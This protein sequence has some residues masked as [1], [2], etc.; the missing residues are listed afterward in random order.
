MGWA[1]PTE[2]GWSALGFLALSGEEGLELFDRAWGADFAQLVRRTLGLGWRCARRRGLGGC[3]RASRSGASACAAWRWGGSLAR[4]LAGVAE[5]EREG[6]VLELVRGEVA[7]VLGHASAAGGR[8]AACVQG[9]GFDSLAAVELRNR[10]G[11]VTGLRLPATLVFDYPSAGGGGGIPAGRG[12]WRSAPACRCGVGREGDREPIAIVGMS[13]RYPGGVSSPEE[14]WD[15][16]AG[17]GD[18]IG[19]FPDDR[20]WNLVRFTIPT[21]TIRERA[22]RVRAGFCMTPPSSTRASLASAH[23]RRWRW[24][25]SSGCC[26]KRVGRLSKTRVSIRRRCRGSQTGVLAGI[27]ASTTMAWTALRA[28]RRALE[29]YGL[30]GRL[31]ECGVGP[32]GVYVWLGGPGGDSR[33][34][35]LFVVGGVASGVWGVALG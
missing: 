3:R 11:S 27:D 21:P 9:L 19:G 13:C 15:L 4:R 30:D 26:W 8:P 31:G 6:V 17:G 35:V 33:Y 25:L 24:T 32:G 16:V 20:G 34:R 12:G 7:A 2:R 22:M 14:L 10:L 18:A 28:R 23:V 5:E 29:G 1:R